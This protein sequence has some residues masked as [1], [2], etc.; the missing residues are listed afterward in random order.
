MFAGENK[1][2]ISVI[3]LHVIVHKAHD[4]WR[5]IYWWLENIIHHLYLQV[6]L[7]R[8]LGV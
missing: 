5:I 7:R 4:H 6:T 2:A 3:R 1:L 8:S